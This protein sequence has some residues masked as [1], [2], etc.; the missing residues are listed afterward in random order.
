MS[1]LGEPERVRLTDPGA[2]KMNGIGICVP[3]PN[4]AE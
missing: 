1:R 3:V 2:R 4:A